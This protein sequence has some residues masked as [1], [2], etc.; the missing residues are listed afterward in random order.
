MDK[1]MNERINIWTKIP[2]TGHRSIRATAKK[3]RFFEGFSIFGN[4]N[5]V[6]YYFDSYRQYFFIKSAIFVQTG[7]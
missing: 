6:L 5:I 4:N 2:F 1:R 3:E 7:S